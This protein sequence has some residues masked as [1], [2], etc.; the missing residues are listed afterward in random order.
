MTIL[1]IELASF[2][3]SEFNE[4]KKFYPCFKLIV[5]SVAVSPQSLVTMLELYY[6][7]MG[8]LI[9]TDYL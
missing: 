5:M 3:T 2:G 7:K 9:S 4:K 1:K 6:M 8:L